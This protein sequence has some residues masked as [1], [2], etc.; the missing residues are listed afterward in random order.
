M[1]TA[2]NAKLG[3]FVA[4]ALTLSIVAIFIIGKNK[5]WFTKQIE[6][7]GLFKNVDGLVPGAKAQLSGIVIGEV[8]DIFIV[9]DTAVEVVLN[10]D[11]KYQKHIKEDA[12]LSI[13]SEGLVG[14]KVVNVV[15]GTDKAKP[16]ADKATLKTKNSVNMD[17]IMK[18]VET[19]SLKT[20][21]ITT[22][23]ADI[24]GNVRDG[25]GAVGSLF[26]DSSIGKD[27]KQTIR[28]LNTG[29][30]K[31]DQNLEAAKHSF[32]LKGYFK[33][34]EKEAEKKRE[35][36]KNNKNGKT[37]KTKKHWLW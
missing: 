20:A 4:A 27:L 15:P 14:N 25:K 13:G 23:L 35:E 30:Q 37:E 8:S 31:L 16:V 28:N 10:V 5:N 34:K 29:S 6:I 32:L 18:N 33:K 7:I 11:A 1:N 36:E 26:N 3:L 21:D 17:A 24:L 12:L 9:S 2:K 22:S 19:V